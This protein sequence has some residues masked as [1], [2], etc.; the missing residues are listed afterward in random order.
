M[1]R[2]RL[3][4]PYSTMPVGLGLLSLQYVVDVISLVTGRDPPFG[5][6]ASEQP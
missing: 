1:W 3:W 2:A 5:I 4:I 6:K